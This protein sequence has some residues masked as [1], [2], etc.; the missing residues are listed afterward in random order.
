ML[1][2]SLTFLLLHFISLIL[3]W[4]LSQQKARLVVLLI[5]SFVFYG[6]L[7][8]PGLILLAATILINYGLSW[9]VDVHRK[10]W[11]FVSSIVL[12]LLNLSWFKYSTFL[13]SNLE[14]LFQVFN[15]EITIPKPSYWLPL[16]IS[17]YTF[18]FLGYLIDLYRGDVKHERSLL[19]FAVFKCL[20][21][22]LIAGPIVRAKE[23]L[24]QLR[25]KMTF[26][27]VQFQKGF[28]L[29]VGGL[30]I[31]ICVADTLSQFV[32]HGFENA[33][34]TS[35]LHT[36]L[37]LYGFAFQILSDFWGYS[38][39]AVGI[40]L[41][42]GIH[43][44]NNFNLPYVAQTLQDFWRRWHITLSIWF[45]DYLYIP[46]GG[47]KT[48]SGPYKNII[49]TMIIAGVWHGAGWNFVFWGLGHGLI[50]AI[51]RK[52]NINKIKSSNKVIA[53]LR[54]ILIFNL[55]CLLWVFFRAVDFNQAMVFFQSM[56]LP[57]YS[58]RIAHLETLIIILILFI[59]LHQK[60]GKL[61]VGDNFI[62]LSTRKQV[63]IT[64][65]LILLTIAYA[66][67]R[68]D[69]IYFIF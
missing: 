68:L 48:K 53:A 63:T 35:T 43:L 30:C 49:I 12:N 47:N 32:D 54:T 11:I 66:D 69:F 26:D 21:A 16:G 27:L 51:E 31:K 65:V 22:Q 59:L 14:S 36:W 56:F 55:V 24:P 46:L 8:W 6:W 34:T 1:F 25:E 42:Y 60:L 19:R 13:L 10:K 2:N 64:T 50:L 28:F 58:A 44:P 7:Y 41:M 20:Y 18:Q 40:G 29:V 52:F 9:A 62:N 4:V 33:A 3:Y 45:R 61:F 17:F 67:A 39:I 15:E 37:S 5:S 57:P 23:L 38:T